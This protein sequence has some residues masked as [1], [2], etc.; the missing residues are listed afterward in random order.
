MHPG[1]PN[2]L[3][4]AIDL[5][6]HLTVL[7]NRFVVLRGLISLGKVRVEIILA[8]KLIRSVDL[9]LGRQTIRMANSTTFLLRTGKTPGIPWHT[10]QVWVFGG[11]PNSVEHPQKIFD[12]VSTGHVFQAL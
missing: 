1:N 2:Y 11:A 8:S 9:R 3:G 4:L 7:D 10:G 5:N 12:A 6:F